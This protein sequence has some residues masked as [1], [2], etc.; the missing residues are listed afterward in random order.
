[1][2]EES[3]GRCLAVLGGAENVGRCRAVPCRKPVAPQT[4]PDVL[5]VLDGAVWCWML[6]SGARRC[7]AM[8]ED[9]GCFGWC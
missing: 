7:R 2:L 9:A 4:S 5:L 8:P 1:M 6:P 3:I